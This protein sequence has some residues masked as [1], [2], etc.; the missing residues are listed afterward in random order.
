M[1]LRAL[2][3]VLLVLASVAALPAFPSPVAAGGPRFRKL[4]KP[5]R[6]NV[7]VG[8]SNDAARGATPGRVTVVVRGPR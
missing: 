4:C 2:V 3:A 7:A 5:G 8:R 1:A 6:L